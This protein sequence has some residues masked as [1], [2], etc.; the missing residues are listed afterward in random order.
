MEGHKINRL[1]LLPVSIVHCADLHLDSSFSNFT[2]SSSGAITRRED[3]KAVFSNIIDYVSRSHIDFLIIAGDLFDSR[4]ATPESIVFLIN[5]FKTIPETEI[6]IT[7]G[8]HD[9]LTPD[10]PYSTIKWPE[11]VHIFGKNLTFYEKSHVRIYGAGF[12]GHF[13]KKSLLDTKQSNF[14]I[15][16][17]FLNI[18]VMHGDID[19]P[20]VYNPI[21]LNDLAEFGFDYCALG[22]VHKFSGVKY[23]G[24]TPYA[25]SGVPEGRGFDESGLCGILSGQIGRDKCTLSFVPT[26]RRQYVIQN[27]NISGCLNI[28]E[29]CERILRECPPDDNL[30]KVLLTGT[31]EDHIVIK[32]SALESRLAD[33]YFYIKIINN[34]QISIN[35]DLLSKE[36]SLRGIFVRKIN[37][38]I[39][40]ANDTEKEQLLEALKYGLEALNGGDCNDDI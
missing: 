13:S 28:D 14:I 2:Y 40:N 8:N 11:N 27:I 18:L 22:H 34:T 20:S 23:V 33:N 9:P 15:D 39:I 7:P 24:T 36:N 6:C 29:I 5:K 31:L 10:S 38:K 3:Q 21:D 26:S 30:Y 1:G 37:E 35:S 4:K 25:Y 16:T 32:T 17:T 12:E 19:S